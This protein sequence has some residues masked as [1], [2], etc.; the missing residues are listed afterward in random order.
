MKNVKDFF[1]E[2]TPEWVNEEYAERKKYKIIDSFYNC[3]K[4]VKNTKPKIL[5]LGCGVGYNSLILRSLGCNVTGIDFS[6]KSVEVA[7]KN[8]LGVDFVVGSISS[9]KFKIKSMFDGAICLETLDYIK[10]EKMERTFSNIAGV[11]KSGALLLVSVLDGEGTNEERSFVSAHGEEYDKNFTCYT[12]EK[13]CTFA[14]PKF[15]L[16]DTWQFNDF[17]DG[18]RYYV[19]ER[20]NQ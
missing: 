17:D 18:W 4:Q 19:F 8:V 20:T 12:A 2:N 14:Y 3:Y 9:K 13:L 5:D 6:K 7:K 10:E 11:L 15:K 1:N 16:V